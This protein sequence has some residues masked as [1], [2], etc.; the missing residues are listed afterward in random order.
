M[1]RKRKP[2][3]LDLRTEDDGRRV[4]VIRDGQVYRRTGCAERETEAAERALK[5]YIDGK[6][7]PDTGNGR[8]SEIL[9][10]DVLSLYLDHRLPIDHRPKDFS[11]AIGRLNS[12]WGKK[13]V[14][15]I[16]GETCRAFVNQRG[17]ASGARRDL[18]DLRSAI[19]HYAAEYGLDVVPRFTLPPKSK[20]RIRWITRQE[21]AALLRACRH[22]TAGR[23]S[24]QRR[25]LARFILIGLYTG[26]RHKA[27]LGLQWM[28]NTLGGWVDLEAGIMHRRGD[29]QAETKKRQ[30]PVRIPPRLLAHMK[31][32]RRNDK[33][34]RHVVHY[35][36]EPIKRLERSFRFTRV[37]A[38]LDAGVT[39]HTLRHTAAT[40]RMQRG[41]DIWETA[42][43]LGMTVETLEKHYGHH[44][45]DFQKSAAEA[46]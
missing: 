45:P 5:D 8:A 38:G 42:G 17:T 9:I 4:W 24:H 6:H 41:I 25:H 32:W 11:A 20:A 33:G 39:P 10:A 37:D 18:E 46:Y 26:T 3:R 36:G 23:I 15:D 35:A 21:A 7:Q 40:W 22:D 29:G 43:F 44:H 34:I 1:P 19:N 13:T 2:P 30:P 16:K 31:R 12:F 27:I 14:S 28:P